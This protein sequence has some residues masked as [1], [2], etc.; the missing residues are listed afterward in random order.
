MES[1]Q[2][3]VAVDHLGLVI[4]QKE[5]GMKKLYRKNTHGAM[6]VSERLN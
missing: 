2:V 1:G 4:D 5:R 6:K 3:R